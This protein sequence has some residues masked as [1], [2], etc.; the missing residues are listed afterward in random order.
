MKD[1][2]VLIFFAAIVVLALA[3]LIAKEFAFAAREK[4]YGEEKYFW[5]SFL[6]GI[7]G[8]LIVIALPCK[9]VKTSSAEKASEDE[10]PEL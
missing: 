4:G 6:F 8:W 3:I 9:S 10:I 7:V 1:Y 2:G 5:Y